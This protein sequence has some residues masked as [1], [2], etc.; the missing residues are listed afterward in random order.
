MRALKVG[1]MGPFSLSP[2]PPYPP[3]L[4]SH[5]PLFLTLPLSLSIYFYLLFPLHLSPPPSHTL[6][7]SQARRARR[8]APMQ[9]LSRFRRRLSSSRSSRRSK[10]SQS[11]QLYLHPKPH[12]LK[13]QA[14][15][16][17]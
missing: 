7:L 3:L 14:C 11:S 6:R 17:E 4:L 5:S 2:P 12:I 13:S 9:L 15:W 8:A 16:H 10:Q 1:L